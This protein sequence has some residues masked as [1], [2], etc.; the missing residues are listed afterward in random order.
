MKKRLIEFDILRGIAFILVVVQ[1]TIGGYSYSQKIS[2]Q[3]FLLSKFIY[4]IAEP[5]VKLFLFLTGV[6]LVYTYFNKCEL[7]NFYIKKIKFLILP[8]VIFSFLNIIL[9]NNTNRL[10]D[11]LM[12][13]ATGNSAYHLW[14]MAMILRVYIYFPLIILLIRRIHKKSI[15][16]K[17][18]FLVSYIIGYI[19]LLKNNTKISNY[20]GELIFLNPSHLQQKFINITPIFWS[21]YLVLGFYVILNYKVFKNFIINHKL[22]IIISYITT[23]MFVY[24]NQ[25][26]K[27][28]LFPIVNKVYLKLNYLINISNN[29]LTILFLYIVSL[30]ILNNLKTIN[31]ILNLIGKFSFPSYMF[32][33]IVIQRLVM[34]VPQTK[35]LYSPIIL[36]ILTVSITTFIFYLTSFLPYSKYIIGVKSHLN[37]LKFNKKENIN[38]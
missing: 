7:K 24:L 16:F 19:I 26:K 1:H 9:L 34:F 3:N 23:F 25:I 22:I 20:L 29:I 2:Y 18:F 35:N 37:I 14:Y 12:E 10:N 32:H 21:L 6:S 30:Y 36:L 13:I 31:K 38:Y 5:A 33:I 4:V 8:Y 27:Q 17:A 15:F 11:F 28:S